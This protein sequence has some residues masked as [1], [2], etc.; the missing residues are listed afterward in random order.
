VSF[1]RSARRTLF[2]NARTL[3]Q[4]DRT[5]RERP[6]IPNMIQEPAP[7]SF[8]SFAFRCK[9]RCYITPIHNPCQQIF[10]QALL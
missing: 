2:S 7:D 9:H 5:Q 4:R 1:A 10:I 8:G 3:P 6:Q